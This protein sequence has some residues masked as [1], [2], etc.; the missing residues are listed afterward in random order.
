MDQSGPANTFPLARSALPVGCTIKC[1]AVKDYKDGSVE[2]C[3]EILE[4][5]IHSDIPLKM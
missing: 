3:P 5:L 4:A 2:S 1:R